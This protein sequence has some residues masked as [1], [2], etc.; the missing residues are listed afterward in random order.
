[1]KRKFAHNI[2]EYWQARKE[3]LIKF[4]DKH[5]D[6]GIKDFTYG[7][8]KARSDILLYLKCSA[9]SLESYTSFNIS[10]LRVYDVT[11]QEKHDAEV[12]RDD[13]GFILKCESMIA[14]AAAAVDV[15]VTMRSRGTKTKS[16]IDNIEKDLDLLLEKGSNSIKISISHSSVSILNNK[17]DVDNPYKSTF[18]SQLGRRKNNPL[19][20]AEIISEMAVGRGF[21]VEAISMIK[22][23]DVLPDP[24]IRQR[25][26]QI[27]VLHSVNEKEK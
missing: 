27:K 6:V 13:A 5:N 2:E 15:N 10:Y 9:R 11:V 7:F 25:L 16:I 18:F 12:K 24:L 26:A 23:G 1:M 20:L 17:D 14:E 8:R 4:F 19:E 22:E 21:K 3:D